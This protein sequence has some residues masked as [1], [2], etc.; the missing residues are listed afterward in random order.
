M[1]V[2]GDG[3]YITYTVLAWKNKSFGNGTSFAW[4]PDSNTYAVL[5]SKVKLKLFKIFKE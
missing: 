1:T 5:E 3:E 4:A 2:V